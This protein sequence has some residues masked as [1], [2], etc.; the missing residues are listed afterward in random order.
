MNQL[1]RIITSTKFQMG[2]AGI[3][4]GIL[5]VFFDVDYTE[6]V[7][8][9]ISLVTVSLVGGQTI[10]DHKYGSPSDGTKP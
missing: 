8:K 9:L 1:K 5:A 3:I 6:E 2:I 10:L 4:G 7:L